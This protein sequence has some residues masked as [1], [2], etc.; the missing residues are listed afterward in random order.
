[1]VWLVTF[2]LTFCTD[3]SQNERVDW[4]CKAGGL[5][6][7]MCRND[8][9]KHMPLYVNSAALPDRRLV[10]PGAH[11]CNGVELFCPLAICGQDR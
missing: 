7:R 6:L 10:S 9:Q 1:M 11:Q 3:C 4:L 8:K 2:C 5:L